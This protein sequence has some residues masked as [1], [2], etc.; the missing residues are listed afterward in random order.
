LLDPGLGLISG[1]TTGLKLALIL[2]LDLGLILYLDHGL[3]LRHKPVLELA[4]GLVPGKS[5]ISLVCAYINSILVTVAILAGIRLL[6]R[7]LT[8]GRNSPASCASG[9]ITGGHY[10]G[11]D[12]DQGEQ[13]KDTEF[14]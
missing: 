6:S 10:T 4:L 11:R 1:A 13:G 8:S 9:L 12:D 5:S 14:L 2:V 7:L 3:K